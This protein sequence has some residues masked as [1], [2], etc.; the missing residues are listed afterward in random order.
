MS[1]EYS[2]EISND[3]EKLFENKKGYDVVKRNT[4]FSHVRKHQRHKSKKR[5]KK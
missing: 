1:F 5:T 4:D 2:Q 3:Y